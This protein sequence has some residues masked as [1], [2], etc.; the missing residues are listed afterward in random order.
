M[1][2]AITYPC[3]EKE[4]A[5]KPLVSLTDQAKLRRVKKIVKQG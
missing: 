3:E 1:R 2:L 5:A 4:T